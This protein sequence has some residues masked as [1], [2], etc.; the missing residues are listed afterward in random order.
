MLIGDKT[1]Y[2]P[3]HES[4]DQNTFN[5]SPTNPIDIWGPQHFAKPALVDF[6]AQKYQSGDI[7]IDFDRNDSAVVPD[8]ERPGRFIRVAAQDVFL[9]LNTMSTPGGVLGAVLVEGRRMELCMKSALAFQGQE[10]GESYMHPIHCGKWGCPSC[11]TWKK[12]DGTVHRGTIQTD[13][14]KAVYERILGRDIIEIQDFRE[15]IG[16]LKKT[17]LIQ[18]VF[19]VPEEF[20]DLFRSKEMLNSL[21]NSARHCLEKYHE[22]DG[23]LGYM[24]LMGDIEEG[25][26]FN[27]HA[28]V[29][30]IQKGIRRVIPEGGDLQLQLVK[31]QFA[32][33]LIALGC[34]LE[35]D[36]NGNFIVNVHKEFATGNT[37]KGLK[38][39]MHH[40]RYMCKPIDR[41]H[42]DYLL[43]NNPE[44]LHFLT[45]G[46]KNYRFLRY[47]SKL[48]NSK[49][50][51]WTE[52]SIEDEEMKKTQMEKSA[53]EKLTY[54]GRTRVSVQD[55]MNRPEYK[56]EK[57]GR[58]L[59]KISRL[60]GGQVFENLIPPKPK[61]PEGEN[62]DE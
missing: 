29:H 16:K 47:W 27:P 9:I 34:K 28:N 35:K 45:I 41:N 40:I 21:F 11:G 39:I 38:R 48:S 59:Y 57:V 24:H 25:H 12:E 18:Y 58:R 17:T 51:E 31:K 33:A 5:P 44:L 50:R 14:A 42:Y 32:K 3:F 56:V 26:E 49:F 62:S 60:D 46:V 55:F 43:E 52:E 10:T 19:T 6:M 20:R 8:P 30:I 37:T 4:Q 1:H 22:D 15:L 36:E 13:R 61:K 53:G 54:L 23:M 2:S 7:T